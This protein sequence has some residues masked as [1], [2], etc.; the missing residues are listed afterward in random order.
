[1]MNI[2]ITFTIQYSSLQKI[3]SMSNL[4]LQGIDILMNLIPNDNSP[5]VVKIKNIDTKKD[6]II[7]LVTDTEN[8]EVKC[9]SKDVSIKELVN[10]KCKRGSIIRIL[11]W[12]YSNQFVNVLKMEL[13]DTPDNQTAQDQ[14]HHLQS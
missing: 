8:K 3:K 7:L 2:F 6:M 11:S 13:A 12:A 5:V 4:T 1:M 14:S 10:T 9:W